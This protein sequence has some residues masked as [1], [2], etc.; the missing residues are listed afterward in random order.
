MTQGLI[1]GLALLV[2]LAQAQSPQQATVSQIRPYTVETIRAGTP[3]APK[4]Q[5]PVIV[6]R[7]MKPLVLERRNRVERGPC[8]M[9]IIVA[10]PTVD[11]KMIFPVEQRNVDAKIRTAEPA[12]CGGSLKAAIKK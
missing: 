7:D 11:L 2:L 8:N 3:R 4:N 5:Q 1:G 9:P 6:S 10:D 12:A